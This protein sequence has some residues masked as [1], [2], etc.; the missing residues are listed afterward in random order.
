MQE[1]RY[2]SYYIDFAIGLLV[3]AGACFDAYAARDRAQNQSS[4]APCAR[5]VS[6]QISVQTNVSRIVMSN[7]SLGWGY[8]GLEPVAMPYE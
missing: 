2:L 5:R 4:W 6:V 7:I 1:Y 3:G 8:A